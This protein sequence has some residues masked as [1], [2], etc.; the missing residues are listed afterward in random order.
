MNSLNMC[1]DIMVIL[2]DRICDVFKEY[3]DAYDSA[4]TKIKLKIDH[5]YRVADISERIANSLDLATEDVELAWLIGMLHDIGRFEQVRR[6]NTFS[7]A[8]SIDHAIFGAQLLFDEG[9]IEKFLGDN[10]LSTLEEEDLR[11]LSLIKLAISNHSAYRIADNL[12]K[13]EKMFCNIIRDADK[14][15][16]LKVNS[17]LPLEEIYNVS[18]SKLKSDPV[19]PKV[20][21]A[22]YEEHAV[23]RKYKETSVDNVVGHISL[24]YELVYAKSY[25]ILMEQRYIYK[26]MDFESDNPDTNK[27][28]EGIRKYMGDFLVRKSQT[29]KG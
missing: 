8:D 9:L 12:S 26:L 11:K 16:I 20:L 19:T 6:Y 4:D 10:V 3:T 5:T 7:D 24:V 27:T 15:D 22:F 21:E 17:D 25:E 29:K 14:I 1:G 18:T 23:L 13:E 28:F 2:R